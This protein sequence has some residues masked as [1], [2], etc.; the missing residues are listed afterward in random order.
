VAVVTHTAV[1]DGLRIT[2]TG[3]RDVVGST[4]SVV[5]VSALNTRSTT[6]TGSLG[7][8]V[9]RRVV[10][11]ATIESLLDTTGAPDSWQNIVIALPTSTQVLDGAYEQ[12][13]WPIEPGATRT[14]SVV[15]VRFP[16]SIAAT[17]P[18]NGW[19]P[20]VE[21]TKRHATYPDGRTYPLLSVTTAGAPG[22][23]V[24]PSAVVAA[25]SGDWTQVRETVCIDAISDQLQSDTIGRA[26]GAKV[27]HEA[28]LAAYTPLVERLMNMHEL[29]DGT[30][31]V[32]PV[33]DP[34]VENPRTD[35]LATTWTVHGSTTTLW[36]CFTGGTVT[37]SPRSCTSL[38]G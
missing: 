24:D 36:A 22:G 21:S 37:V 16:G 25:C 30:G 15:L 38:S 33:S 1:V 27:T 17:P 6:W 10:P 3:P 29:L 9:L 34:A 20:L 2:T 23:E 5:T 7:A 26:D 8:S 14:I 31:L 28:F 35:P 18:I 4:P 32:G 19:V 11:G 12:Q 13:A